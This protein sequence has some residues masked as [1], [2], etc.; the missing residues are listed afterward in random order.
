MKTI[1]LIASITLCAVIASAQYE[2]AGDD[3]SALSKDSLETIATADG[4][5]VADNG[6]VELRPEVVMSFALERAQE[7]HLSD[8]VAQYYQAYFFAAYEIE[9]TKNPLIRP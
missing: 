2:S 9:I 3:L 4:K 1:I 7:H 6:P 8:G 5:I